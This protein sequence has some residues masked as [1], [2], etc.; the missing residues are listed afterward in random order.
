MNKLFLILF[1]GSIVI[2]YLMDRQELRK[3]KTAEKW[4]YGLL[5]GGAAG[6]GLL[7]ITQIRLPM[8]TSWMVHDIVPAIQRYMMH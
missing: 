2:S 1:I 7:S 4:F 8:P 3:A 6:L 5:M